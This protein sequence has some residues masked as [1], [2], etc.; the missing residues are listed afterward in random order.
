MDTVNLTSDRKK[1]VKR[2]LTFLTIVDLFFFPIYCVT[3][4]IVHEQFCHQ[5]FSFGIGLVYVI[6]FYSIP[7]S[8][9]I[10]IYLMWSNYRK[11]QY[12][13]AYIYCASPILIWMITLIFE[14]IERKL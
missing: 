11:C 6:L 3:A 12:R 14:L 4:L 2:W 8:I 9:P 5:L 10:S 13:R 1:P 7:V